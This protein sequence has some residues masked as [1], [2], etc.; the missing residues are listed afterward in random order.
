VVAYPPEFPSD[1]SAL[2]GRVQGR[3]NDLPIGGVSPESLYAAL[4][5][6]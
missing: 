2:V 3:V 4:M 6:P 5:G 1:M